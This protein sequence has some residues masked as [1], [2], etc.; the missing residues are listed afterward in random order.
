MRGRFTLT[1][2][3]DTEVAGHISSLL[4]K[5]VAL[6][7]KPAMIKHSACTRA[8]TSNNHF[9]PSSSI[10]RIA[11]KVEATLTTP[12]TM[13]P[14]QGVQFERVYCAVVRR[15]GGYG[16]DAAPTASIKK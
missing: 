13:V 7:I 9:R 5:W 14:V 4:I 11:K 6:I 2:H 8:P 12:I 10:K 1:L 15:K 16:T 3:S